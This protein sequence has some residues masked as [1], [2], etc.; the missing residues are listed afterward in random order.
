MTEDNNNVSYRG[1]K[2]YGVDSNG[3]IGESSQVEFCRI[4]MPNGDFLRFSSTVDASVNVLAYV[5]GETGATMVLAADVGRCVGYAK[6]PLSRASKSLGGDEW[7]RTHMAGV[8]GTPPVYVSLYSS[9]DLVRWL[10]A[11]IRNLAAS[12][13][14]VGAYKAFV[15]TVYRT[16]N[17][18]SEGA[19]EFGFHPVTSGERPYIREEADGGAA[20]P[21]KSGKDIKGIKEAKAE[22]AAMSAADTAKKL[23]KAMEWSDGTV[24]NSADMAEWMTEESKV[25]ITAEMVENTLNEK[26]NGI[27]AYLLPLID[28][29]TEYFKDELKE[30]PDAAEPGVQPGLADVE[31]AEPAAAAE[32]PSAE[33]ASLLRAEDTSSDMYELLGKYIAIRQRATAKVEAICSAIGIKTPW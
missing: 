22:A 20:T 17:A 24:V 23:R 9:I 31:E 30:A 4:P 18:I 10:L 21:K 28:V 14:S 7:R 5:S 2:Y 26:D 32:P 33:E 1:K 11:N 3:S 16:S 13:F 19:Y 12:Q 6:P 27:P 29:F 15:N 25:K 8:H